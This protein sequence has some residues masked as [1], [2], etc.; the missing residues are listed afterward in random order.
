VGNAA[1]GI[2]CPVLAVVINVPVFV[3][4]V[5]VKLLAEFGAAT[6]NTPAPLAFPEMATEL[7]FYPLNN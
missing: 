6:V 1:L 2:T 5:S 4:N 7:M 3:G